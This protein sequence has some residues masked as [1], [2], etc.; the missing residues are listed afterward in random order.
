MK[1]K[2]GVLIVLVAGV[3]LIWVIFS[4]AQLIFIKNK[5]AHTKATVLKVDTDCDRYNRIEVAFENK[6][7]S[8]NI[9][10]SD[11]QNRAY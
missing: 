10:R 11:C 2:V 7:Y 3:L 9:S 1:N 8:V 5:G 6:I 4:I